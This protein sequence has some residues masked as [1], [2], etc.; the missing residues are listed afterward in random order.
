MAVS[1][2]ITKI[3]LNNLWQ[4]VDLSTDNSFYLIAIKDKKAAADTI[5]SKDVQLINVAIAIDSGVDK[6]PII[7]QYLTLNFKDS[8]NGELSTFIRCDGLSG[9]FYIK[10]L[11]IETEKQRFTEGQTSIGLNINTMKI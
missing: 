8:V 5:D 4:Q 11:S 2:I 1:N 3:S 7:I 9:K 10:V 6:Q